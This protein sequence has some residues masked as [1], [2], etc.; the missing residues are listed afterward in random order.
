MSISNVT[1]AQILQKGA[2]LIGGGFSFF[3]QKILPDFSVDSNK[4]KTGN[5]N[6]SVAKAI[7]DNSF[8]GISIGYGGNIQ[9][10]EAVNTNYLI[11][12]KYKVQNFT[13]SVFYR[14]YKNLGNNFYLFGQPSLEYSFS[15][16]S[17]SYNTNTSQITKMNYV[18]FGLTPGISYKIY[19]KLFV[20]VA[21]PNIFNI[22]Y[23]STKNG[24][25]K[26]NSLGVNSNLSGF[27]I[28]SFAFGF[29]FIL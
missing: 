5:I 14:R 20:D 11:V 13:T 12:Q 24:V 4:S 19:R 6:I 3:Q 29:N 22:N 8:L 21:I 25:G 16:N 26:T 27:N 9:N 17:I 1:N 7:L 18:G 23:T 15:K 2:T 10:H 28:N